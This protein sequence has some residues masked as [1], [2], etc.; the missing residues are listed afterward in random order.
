[1]KKVT[2]KDIA[3]EAGVS[4][5]TVSR[6]I[7]KS[8]PV[9][10][11]LE[12]KVLEVIRKMG[13]TPNLV[14]RSLRKGYTDTVGFI[15]P[16]ITNPFFSLI[17]KGA[18]DFFKKKKI[19][20]V[21][22]SSNHDV[23]EEEKL[24][25]MLVSKKMD[26]LLLV[27]AGSSNRVLNSILNK[28]KVVFVDRVYE[29]YD[30]PYVVSDNYNGMKKLVWYLVK[31]GH[32]SFAFLNGEEGTYS[33]TERLRGFVDA[34]KEAGIKDYVVFFGQFT[35]ESGFSLVKKLGKIPDAVVCGNDLMAYGAIDALEEMGYEVPKNVSV[36]GFDDLPFSKHYK[37]SLT[38]VRQPFHAMGYESAKILHWMISGK[39]K[40]NKKIVLETEL[41]IRE[42]TKGGSEYETSGNS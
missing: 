20:L 42:S 39:N 34:L 23:K 21:V 12:E 26:G 5:S 8:A 36:T 33:A 16:D 7:N 32:R 40:K 35:Y 15:V 29:G 27:G 9:R 38:T 22:C 37:P 30:A 2:I 25:E 17:I 10:K 11:E 18:E 14:A 4:P 41:I 3:R 31:T 19:S 6:V 24:I 13:Y 28:V 1:M